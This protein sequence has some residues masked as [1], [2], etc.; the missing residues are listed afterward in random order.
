[1]DRSTLCAI[2]EE[3]AEK[4]EKLRAFVDSKGERND[5][6]ASE[7]RAYDRLERDFDAVDARYQAACREYDGDEPSAARRL[8]RPDAPAA[9]QRAEREERTP[10]LGERRM[11]DVVA[12]QRNIGAD[13]VAEAREFSVGSLLRAMIVGDAPADSPERRTILGNT[14]ASGGVMLPT[15][16]AAG[17]IDTLLPVTVLGPAGAQVY[18]M[19]EGKATLPGIDQLPTPAW[20]AWGDPVAESD[21]TFLKVSLEAQHAG[22]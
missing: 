10:F 22:S 16:V 5:L 12:E 13:D 2:R 15:L 21:P 11:A 14:D 17:L 20:R 19:S 8:A 9:G 4:Y 1:M 6:T 18:P 3:R 7:Q